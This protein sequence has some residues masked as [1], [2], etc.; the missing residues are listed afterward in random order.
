[1]LNVKER[2]DSAWRIQIPTV[3]MANAAE[4]EKALERA[5]FASP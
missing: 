4:I 3:L 5:E 1:V 2:M